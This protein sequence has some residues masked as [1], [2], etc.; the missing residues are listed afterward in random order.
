[1][2]I[3]KRWAILLFTALV[4]SIGLNLAIAGF[5]AARIWGDPRPPPIGGI[6]AIGIR[7][8]PPEI[9]QVIRAKSEERRPE[10]RT[11]LDAVDAAREQMFEALRADPFDEAILS[12]AFAALRDRTVELQ[13]IGQE[14]VA[15]AVADA[16]AAVRA[17]IKP[18][19]RGGR[20]DGS[21][22]PPPP[23]PG[24]EPLP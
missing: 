11:R 17:E 12:A 16:P 18:P 9:Q 3:R 10:I 23:P 1:M 24:S 19:K 4:V 6:V 7:S 8:F 2:T 13:M 5:T 21:S 22:R 14:M 20:R 15:E